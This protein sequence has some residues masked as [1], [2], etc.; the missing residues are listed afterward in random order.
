MPNLL[1]RLEALESIS[2]ARNNKP[3]G[4]WTDEELWESLGIDPNGPLPTDEEL[5]ALIDSEKEI[6]NAKS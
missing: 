3:F 2:E 1:K 6:K 5:R 4:L